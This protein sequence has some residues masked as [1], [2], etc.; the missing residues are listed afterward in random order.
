MTVD[1]RAYRD[2]L[3][4]FATGIAVVTARRPSGDAG[5]ITI[6]SFSSVSLD[7]PLVLFCLDRSARLFE[8]FTAGQD[9]A[10][11]V[12]SETQLDLSA[13]FASSDEPRWSDLPSETWVSGA[14]ILGGCLAN[15]DCRWVANHA[16]GDHIIVVG[17]VLRF[18]H[19][20]AGSPL[21]YFASAYRG[22]R[23]ADGDDGQT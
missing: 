12:L 17:E 5:G 8:A 22:L 6:N 9:F 18:A 2:A 16:G 15:M 11:N 3:G 23:A 20:P 21:I 1:T 10:V 14:P 13:R 4:R 7:P 19:R